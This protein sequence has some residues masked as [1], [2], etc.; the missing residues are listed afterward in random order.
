[1]AEKI[2]FTQYV[3]S[4]EILKQS[5][6]RLPIYKNLYIITTYCKLSVG[7]NLD[8]KEVI[9]LKPNTEIIIDWQITNDKELQCLRICINNKK[10]KLYWKANKMDKW[11]SKNTKFKEKV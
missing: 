2:S 7:K 3:E 8:N 11:L 10:Y 6:Q 9:Q 4:L 5:L 1:M